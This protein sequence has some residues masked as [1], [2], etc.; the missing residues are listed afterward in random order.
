MCSKDELYPCKIASELLLCT[1]IDTQEFHLEDVQF[2][3]KNFVL[4]RSFISNS[5]FKQFVVFVYSF[6][7][8]TRFKSSTYTETIANPDS[9]FLIKTHGQIGLFANHFFKKYSLR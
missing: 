1:L 4:P 3:R 5:F 6:G 9:D 7:V 8:P 2:A